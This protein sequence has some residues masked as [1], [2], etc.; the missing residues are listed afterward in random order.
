RYGREL[1][2]EIDTLSILIADKEEGLA[3]RH[4]P[5]W[6]AVKVLENDH[7][8]LGRLVSRE[9]TAAAAK[10]TVHLES[11][12]GAPPE[13]AIADRR[14]GFISGA[15]QEVVRSTVEARHTASDRIDAIV[16]NRVLG[17][18]I[19]FGLMYSV[20]WITFAFGADPAD[21]IEAGFRWL[22]GTV[23]GW[24]PRGAESALMSFLA[25]GVI[26][27]FGSVIV[28]LPNIVL[29]FVAIAILEDSGYMARAAFIMDRVMHKIGLHGK[30]FIPMIIGFGCS[31]PAVMATRTVEPRRDRL[32]TILVL[33]L[34][35]C[36]ARLH[37]YMLIAPAFFPGRTALVVFSLY[38]IGIALAILSA[39]VLRATIFKGQ[40]S[41]FVMEL[42]PYRMP[43]VKGVAIHT[44][45]RAWLY[46]KKAATIILGTSIVLWVLTSYP[47]KQQL[48]RDYDRLATRAESKY[49]AGLRSLN[50]ELGLPEDSEVLLNAARAGFDLRT[51]KGPRQKPG[52]RR[53]AENADE[54]RIAPL[55]AGPNGERLTAFLEM[56]EAV[57]SARTEFAEA[58]KDG[59]LQDGSAAYG[60]HKAALVARLALLEAGNPAAFKAAV[61]YLDE[62]GGRYDSALEDIARAKAAEYLSYSVAGRIGRAIAPV[63]R[64]MGFDWR[65]GT[66]LI[67]ALAAKEVF[68]AQLGIVYSVGN[69]GERPGALRERLKVDYSPLVAYC[70]MLFCLISAPCV[71]T[72]AITRR[73]SRSWKWAFFQFGALTALAF[74]V[75]SAAYLTGSLVGIGT[76]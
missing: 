67:G 56:T 49:M 15:C 62:V 19:F 14:Y 4:D 64:P 39:K 69:A 27:G 61:R 36:G 52:P 1:E 54:A 72:I 9:V 47:K 3:R 23:R 30:S 53:V 37:I 22:S 42:P 18:P 59:W 25:D 33:P 31:V 60:A 21:W 24:W 75:T 20:F 50:A 74:V 13:V 71:A 28:F 35:S 70:L 43:T 11:I 66:A 57:A 68:V 55:K 16:T 63:L 2:D 32:V 73:E 12:F 41:P 65:V 76:G 5:R 26:G 48:G 51:E 38:A 17:L 6:L 58:V 45:E 29:L 34:M 8:V 7:E 46:L 10:S 44:W 40:S